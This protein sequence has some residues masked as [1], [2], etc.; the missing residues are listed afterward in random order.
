MGSR[1]RGGGGGGGGGG[2][3]GGAGGGGGGFSDARLEEIVSQAV[4]QAVSAAMRASRSGGGGGGGGGGGMGRGRSWDR[5]RGNGGEGRANSRGGGTS[6]GGAAAGARREGDWNCGGCSFSNFARRG[7]CLRCGLARGASRGGGGGDGRGAGG[8]TAPRSTSGAGG[9]AQPQRETSALGRLTRL[10]PADAGLRPSTVAAGGIARAGNGGGVREGPVG[11]DGR[12]PLLSWSKAASAGI[13][14]QPKAAAPPLAPPCVGADA[15]DR[16]GE[17]RATT[18]SSSSAQRAGLG[19][20]DAGASTAAAS[21]A[22]DDGFTRVVHRRKGRFNRPVGEKSEGAA[23]DLEAGADDDEGGDEDLGTCDDDMDEDEGAHGPSDEPPSKEEL[24]ARWEHEKQLLDFLQRQGRQRHE[25]VVREAWQR[26]EDAKSAWEGAKTPTSLPRRFMRAEESVR[27][28]RKK[29]AALEQEGDDIDEQ[30]KQDRAVV[31]EK[32]AEARRWL[33][34]REAALDA[35][36]AEAAARKGWSGPQPKGDRDA[37][38]GE[39]I[40]GWAASL[41]TKV[42]PRL[43]AALEA[44]SP[45]TQGHA[46]LSAAIALLSG[47]SV[48]AANADEQCVA[49]RAGYYDIGGGDSGGESGPWEP[50]QLGGEWN[51]DR[52]RGEQRWHGDAPHA[53]PHHYSTWQSPAGWQDRARW[54]DVSWY[55]QE[56]AARSNDRFQGHAAIETGGSTQWASEEERITAERAYALQEAAV[57]ATSASG[58][59]TANATAAA[60]SVHVQRILDIKKLADDNGV[61]YDSAQ[62]DAMSPAEA[63]DWARTYLGS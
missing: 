44:M 57:A 62:L 37:M 17:D 9:G 1:G 49:E 48:E 54:G 28:A 24:K 33:R 52:Q 27:K 11:A 51:E 39:R 15:V 56:Q 10:G 50:S 19:E 14:A 35:V 42:A 61:Q 3:N 32:L 29:I 13:S 59:A 26:C 46:E 41:D 45:G 58:F 22:E 25:D 23:T 7:R 8:G 53:Q 20:A 31:D 16:R 21:S 38:E 2:G 60:A 47:L 55:A 5:Q 36:H 30:Y 63:E 18:D 4:S 12:K 40:R 43:Q 6:G 34:E